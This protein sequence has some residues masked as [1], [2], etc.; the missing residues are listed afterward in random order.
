[1]KIELWDE[2]TFSDDFIGEGT[3]DFQQLLMYPNKI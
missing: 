2:D 3:I 1:M